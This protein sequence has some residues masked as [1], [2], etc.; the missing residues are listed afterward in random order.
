MPWC[1]VP[2]DDCQVHHLSEWDR[3]HGPT[4]LANGFPLCDPDH[5]HGHDEGYRLVRHADCS[6]TVLDRHGQRIAGPPLSG[7]R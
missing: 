3:D 4:D 5:H 7:P 2:V 1:D 6:V